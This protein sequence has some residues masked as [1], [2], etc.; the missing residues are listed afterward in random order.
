MTKEELLQVINNKDRYFN[1][2]RKWG[3]LLIPKS[4]VWYYLNNGFSLIEAKVEKKKNIVEPKN[5]KTKKEETKVDKNA[6][7]EWYKIQLLAEKIVE[8]K[9]L[10]WKSDEE[11]LQLAKDNWLVD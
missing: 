6:D 7:I 11:I 8:E 9:D 5:S 1:W 10:E 4:R 2:V 3:I